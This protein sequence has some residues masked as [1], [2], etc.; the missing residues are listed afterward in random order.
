M[1]PR[2][3]LWSKQQQIILLSLHAHCRQ[4]HSTKYIQKS[5]VQLLRCNWRQQVPV[6]TLPTAVRHVG[7]PS[8][9]QTQATETVSGK[10]FFSVIEIK[11]CLVTEVYRKIMSAAERFFQQ[12][13]FLGAFERTKLLFWDFNLHFEPSIK[14]YWAQRE[15]NFNSKEQ[16][17]IRS[18]IFN[19]QVHSITLQKLDCNL[20]PKLLVQGLTTDH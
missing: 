17:L 14:C 10:T 2:V 9:I 19:G 13:H 8:F 3:N 11:N 18:M 7:P 20:S 15:T 1:W 5:P 16:L 12:S 4:N 6:H